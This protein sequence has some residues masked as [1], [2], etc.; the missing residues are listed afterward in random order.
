MRVYIQRICWF[1]AEEAFEGPGTPPRT[2]SAQ[3]S[4]CNP[5]RGP[6]GWSGGAHCTVLRIAKLP[7]F[8]QV[9]SFLL[10]QSS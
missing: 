3:A 5:A 1:F 8:R 10:F 6:P 7:R 2:R 9:D 4:H